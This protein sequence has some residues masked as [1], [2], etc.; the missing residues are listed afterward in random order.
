MQNAKCKMSQKSPS[1]SEVRFLG[2]RDVCDTI[3]LI[4]T[5]QL[6]DTGSRK[7]KILIYFEF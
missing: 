7:C 3:S 4:P 6:G 5:N 1:D 2:S